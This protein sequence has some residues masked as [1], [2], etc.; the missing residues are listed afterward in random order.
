MIKKVVFACAPLLFCAH[1]SA[2]T[3]C[4]KYTVI[5][6]IL[7]KETV[8]MMVTPAIYETVY[9]Q[10]VVEDGYWDVVY[11]SNNVPCETYRPAKYAMVAEVVL[12]IPAVYKEFETIRKERDARVI[13]YVSTE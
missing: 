11:N 5:A 3:L 10:I 13:P 12:K 4:T 8:K 2:Q 9:R 6:P 7:K 1:A